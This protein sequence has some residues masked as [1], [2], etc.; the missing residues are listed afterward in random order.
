MR[1]TSMRLESSGI[2]ATARRADS[3]A[4]NRP[5]PPFSERFRRP[6]WTPDVGPEGKLERPS[7]VS[8]RWVWASTRWLISS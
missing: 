3:S 4:R 2:T 8:L 5:L 6:I 1:R 7:M